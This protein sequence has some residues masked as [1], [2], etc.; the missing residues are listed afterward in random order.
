[1]DTRFFQKIV[2]LA[3]NFLF[4]DV[5][6][7]VELPGADWVWHISILVCDCKPYLD[8][9]CFL[10][11]APNQ[12]VLCFLF[13]PWPLEVAFVHIYSW[14]LCVLYS[15]VL[16]HCDDIEFLGHSHELDHLLFEVVSPHVTYSG[17]RKG[18]ELPFFPIEIGI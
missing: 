11:I 10:N 9:F 18:E 5:E 13:S 6:L 15:L 1:M 12:E 2:G 8:Q 3:H 17:V 4:V 7:E 16:Y 14:E